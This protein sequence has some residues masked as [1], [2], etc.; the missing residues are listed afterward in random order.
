MSLYRFAQSLGLMENPATWNEVE[1]LIEKTI[2]QVE[3][4]L[5]EDYIGHSEV[6]R[7]YLALKEAK[8]LKEE[9]CE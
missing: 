8:Y 3:A 6:R 5:A 1:K 9:Y 7:I 4:E 2:E